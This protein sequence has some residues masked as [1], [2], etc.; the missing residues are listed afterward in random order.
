VQ[1]WTKHWPSDEEIESSVSGLP[2]YWGWWLC[3]L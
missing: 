1:N 3:R 2:I